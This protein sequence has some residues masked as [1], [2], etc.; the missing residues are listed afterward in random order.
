MLQLA[1]KEE[2]DG[3]LAFR[4]RGI[5]LLGSNNSTFSKMT[6]VFDSGK[7][8]NEIPLRLTLLLGCFTLFP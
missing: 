3:V 6:V 5:A 7:R 8:N 2:L 4:G 1:S